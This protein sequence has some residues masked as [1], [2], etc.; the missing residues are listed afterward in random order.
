MKAEN[1]HTDKNTPI[2][3]T[4]ILK[5]NPFKVPDG[6]F[7]GLQLS[8]QKRIAKESLDTKTIQF[9][10]GFNWQ[11]SLIAAALTL[12]AVVYSTFQPVKVVQD[13]QQILAEVSI[14]DILDYI[15]YSDLTTSDILAEVNFEENEIDEFIEDDIQLLNSDE[16]ESIDIDALIYEFDLE[17][18]TL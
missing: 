8:I 11:T 18:N 5:E 10:P 12:I 15:D 4:D 9:V 7:E 13:P 6:Y 14:S 1:R 16:F 2:K 17:E 3:L